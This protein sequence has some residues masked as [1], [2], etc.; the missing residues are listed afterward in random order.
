M[1]VIKL[2]G[3]LLGSS[4]LQAWLDLIAKHGDGK[5][6][7]VPGGGM[8]ADAVRQAQL[9]T[10]ISDHTAHQM[11]V[12]AMDQYGLLMKGLNDNLATA[13]SE[14]ELAERGWQHRGIIWLPSKMVCADDD[15]PE[16]WQMTSDSLAAWLAQ[17]LNALH[18]VLIKST[19]PTEREATAKTLAQQDLVDSCLADFIVDQT[20]DTWVLDKDDYSLFT[21]G[22]NPE[23]LAQSALHVI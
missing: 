12:L 4:E 15:I 10:G 23:Q 21:D 20:F 6:V 19:L 17:K 18:L 13:A 5:V 2:G 8:F 11:A 1:W 14:L 16:N 9:D 7:I 22:F 3:S